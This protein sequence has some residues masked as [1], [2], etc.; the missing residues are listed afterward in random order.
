M[1]KPR[2]EA[3]ARM[4][5]GSDTSFDVSLLS[6]VYAYTLSAVRASAHALNELF[7]PDVAYSDGEE[8]HTY[9]LKNS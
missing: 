3:S 9:V 4:L 7:V 2:F 1:Q 5:N 8:S 6:V